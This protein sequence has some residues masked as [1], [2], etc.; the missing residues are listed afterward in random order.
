MNNFTI[1]QKAIGSLPENLSVNL[2]FR[3][4]NYKQGNS[5]ALVIINTLS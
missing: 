4:Q 1:S 5:D 3:K 2:V